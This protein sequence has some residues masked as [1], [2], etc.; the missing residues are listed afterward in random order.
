MKPNT[1]RL[2]TLLS[3]VKNITTRPHRDDETPREPWEL[4]T[5]KME[6][7]ELQFDGGL[8]TGDRTLM[9]MARWG[10]KNVMISLV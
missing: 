7:L 9:E 2:Q 6:Q 1:N 3:M 8:F 5:A 4:V 10:E